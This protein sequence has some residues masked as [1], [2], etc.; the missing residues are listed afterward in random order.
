MRNVFAHEYFGIDS[1]M[2]WE[3]IKTDIPDLKERVET[4]L[5]SIK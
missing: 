1:I 2:V 5:E 4:I 3:I